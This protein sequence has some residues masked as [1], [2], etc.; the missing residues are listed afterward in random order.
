MSI[1]RSILQR[2]LGRLRFPQLFVLVLALFGLDLAIPDVIPFLDEILLGAVTLLLGSWKDRR[3]D[4]TRDTLP[5]RAAGE[6]VGDDPELPG[7][8]DR[9]APPPA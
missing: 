5:D 8:Q 6:G 7:V 1:R 4:R 9:Q 3:V 2:F